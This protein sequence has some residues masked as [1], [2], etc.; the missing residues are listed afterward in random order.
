MRIEKARLINGFIEYIDREITPKLTDDK[1][2]QVILSVGT[3]MVRAN[4]SIA[5]S[6]LNNKFLLPFMG[7][8]EED[9]TYEP[10]A[11]FSTFHDAVSKAGYLPVKI[12][13]ISFLSPTEKTLKFSAE[14]IDALKK[15]VEEA[16]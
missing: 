7:Y 14:D 6:V 8:R 12:P 15:Y 1:A 16:R 13:P 11:L 9:G 3:S 5:D 4:P 10:D 2:M